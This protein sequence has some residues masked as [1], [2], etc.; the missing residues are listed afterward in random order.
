MLN[1][2]RLHARDT[3]A[4]AQGV[5]LAHGTRDVPAALMDGV[6][7]SEKHAAE[8]AFRVNE[9]RRTARFRAQAAQGF[10]GLLGG[11]V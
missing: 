6:A 4:V 11:R 1:L 2:P 10:K 8:L 3:L 7:D 9:R 5:A